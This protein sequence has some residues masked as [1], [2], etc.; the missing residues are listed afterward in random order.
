MSNKKVPQDFIELEHYFS[1]YFDAHIAPLADKAVKDADASYLKEY[2]SLVSDSGL[3]GA[4][5]LSGP[6]AAA[7]VAK[8]QSLDSYQNYWSNIQKSFQK[9]FE[10][11]SDFKADFGKLIDAYQKAMIDKMG[12]EQ[13]MAESRKYG[14]DLAT[15]Y[16]NNKILEK[17][18]NRMAAHGAPKDSVEYL[19]QKGKQLSILGLTQPSDWDGM[20]AL[21]EQQYKP[22]KTEKMAAYGVGGLMDFAVMPVGGMKTAI[23]GTTAG[24]GID[25]VFSS[26]NNRQN[27]DALVSRSVFGNSWT[28]PETRKELVDAKDSDYLTALNAGMKKKVTLTNPSPALKQIAENNRFPLKGT[29]LTETDDRDDIPMIVAPGMEEAYRRDLARLKQETPKPVKPQKKAEPIPAPTPHQTTVNSPSSAEL[30]SYQQNYQYQPQRVN[31][32]GWGGLF[33]S[34][35]LTGFSDVFKNLGYVLAMLPDMM[36]GMFTGKT[37]S[38]SV[39]QNLLPIAAIVM[40]MFV[41]NPLLKMLLIG[42]G[43]ANLLNKATHEILGETPSA[44]EVRY[45]PYADERLNARISHPQLN[46]NLLVATIDGVPSTVTLQ[47]SVVDAYQKGALPINTLANAVLAKYDEQRM[48]VEQNYERQMAESE[49]REISRGIR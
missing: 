22:S 32:N 37:K 31:N 13:Y 30:N 7:A 48:E 1:K 24:A 20:R 36:I 11:S 46:G 21:Q 43:G 17:S 5:T 28:L 10:S 6:R 44:K 33:D 23:I 12:K 29:F 8:S 16:V 42:L 45:R 41:R 4:V 14:Q 19:F 15:W 9:R 39:Q 25:I 34:V 27:V 40:G 26:G 35:G 3:L 18:L 2:G 49:H 38:L 47:E